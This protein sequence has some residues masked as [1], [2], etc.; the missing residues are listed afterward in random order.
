MKEIV[1]FFTNVICKIIFSTFSFFK[2]N[3]ISSYHS[4]KYAQIHI[5]LSFCLLILRRK[6][7]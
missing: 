3:L 6:S 5:L 4:R 7:H 1:T 2:S